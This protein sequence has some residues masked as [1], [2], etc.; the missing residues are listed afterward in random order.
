MS[1]SGAELVPV[2]GVP[3]PCLTNM[4]T[5]RRAVMD[6]PHSLFAYPGHD[7][8]LIWVWCFVADDC[9]VALCYVVRSLSVVTMMVVELW[10]RSGTAER[11]PNLIK[12]SH[13]PM[14]HAYSHSVPLAPGI[15]CRPAK[16]VSQVFATTPFTYPAS[17]PAPALDV[18]YDNSMLHSC[19][20]A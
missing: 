9:C 13:S 10:L 20:L 8:S 6:S 17:S 2:A 5:C 4:P 16:K 3:G 7:H 19:S 18:Y 11:Y 15:E 14:H 12:S 1:C